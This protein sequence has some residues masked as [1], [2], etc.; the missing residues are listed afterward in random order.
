RRAQSRSSRAPVLEDRDLAP[1]PD[2]DRHI[3]R[4]APLE[5]LWRWINPAM[6]YNKHLGFK[7][8][9]D[10]ELLARNPK[11]LELEQSMRSLK[12]ELGKDGMSANC[13]WR[14]YQAASE[15]NALLLFEPGASE[16]ATRFEFPRELRDDGLCISDFVRPIG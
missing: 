5:E 8:K 3:L 1:A 12:D 11:A 15:G 2:L 4:N 6:L 16:P 9:W 10:T 13:V 7:G 14:F